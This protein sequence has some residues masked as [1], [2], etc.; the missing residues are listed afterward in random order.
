[1]KTTTKA[2]RRYGVAAPPSD[3]G[4]VRE[5]RLTTA[6]IVAEL[7]VIAKGSGPKA[8]RARQALREL[9]RK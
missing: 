6:E 4:T 1:M 2:I 7:E 9:K 8:A 5:R 3:A